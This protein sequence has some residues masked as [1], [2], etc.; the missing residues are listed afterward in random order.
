[1]KNK[2]LLKSE[3]YTL[4]YCFT[5]DIGKI[6]N[7]HSEEKWDLSEILSLK[8]EV[9]KYAADGPPTLKQ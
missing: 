4:F 2:L 7:S 8:C 9:F 5:N 1:M 6:L 3:N